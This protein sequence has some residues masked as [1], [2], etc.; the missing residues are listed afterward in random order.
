MGCRLELEE[1]VRLLESVLAKIK[2]WSNEC[3]HPDIMIWGTLEA[4]MRRP[5]LLIAGRLNEGSW[6]AQV[7]SDP[8]LNRQMRKQAGML[9]PER[10]I[11]LSAHDFQQ[12]LCGP[13]VLL[14]RTVSLAKSA[15]PIAFRDIR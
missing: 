5:D 15:D 1:Y 3:T 4:R 13:E 12:V 6:P 9:V 2:V 8:W 14:T 11:G 10:K 7:S